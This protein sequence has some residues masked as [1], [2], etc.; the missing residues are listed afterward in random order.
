M[1]IKALNFFQNQSNGGAQGITPAQ[2]PAEQPIQAT[3][4]ITGGANPF[5]QKDKES[6]GVG[7]VQSNLQ[8]MS[9]ALPNG[10]TSNCNT[11]WIA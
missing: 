2:K 4:A 7:L 10:K 8:N 5:A 3:Q 1:S 11:K 6:M 9:Y